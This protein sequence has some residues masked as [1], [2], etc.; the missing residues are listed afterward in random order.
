MRINWKDILKGVLVAFLTVVVM[1]VYTSLQ[2]GALPTLEELKPLL[3][4]G[5]GAALAY[6]IKN[7][8]SSSTGGF[9]K[10]ETT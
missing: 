1:G 9:M 6:L 4:T 7:F 5:L 3:I 2:T 8:F 10:K